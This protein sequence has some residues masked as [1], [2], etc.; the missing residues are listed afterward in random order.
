LWL[1]NKMRWFP[2]LLLTVTSAAIGCGGKQGTA[3]PSDYVSEAMAD[4]PYEYRMLPRLETDDYSA[5]EIVHPR[6]QVDVIVAFGL[7]SME[8]SCPKPPLPFARR[9]ESVRHFTG[10]SAHPLICFA[11]NSW[12]SVDNR[13]AAIIGGNME[14]R[15]VVALCEAVYDDVPFED[16]VCFD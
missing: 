10:A 13:E 16:F 1:N 2:V 7:P 11:S 5:F 14:R 4:L 8:N 9:P 12:Q 6:T 15:T 3:S